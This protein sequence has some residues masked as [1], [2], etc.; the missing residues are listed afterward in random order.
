MAKLKYITLGLAL[1][2]LAAGFLDARS[3]FIIYLGPPVGTILLGLFLV[4]QVLAKEWAVD[5]EQNCPPVPARQPDADK[6]Q[7]KTIQEVAHH[8]ALTQAYPH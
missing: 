2:A 7:P 1:M 6:Q 8:P 4:T 5:N 3:N